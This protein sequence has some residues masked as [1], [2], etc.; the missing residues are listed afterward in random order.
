MKKIISLILA[1]VLVL[2]M[3]MIASATTYDSDPTG[4]EVQW[5]DS[6]TESQTAKIL[7]TGDRNPVYNVEVTWTSLEF[8]YSYGDDLLWNP[9]THEYDNQQVGWGTRSATVTVVNHSNAQVKCTVSA[10]DLNGRDAYSVTLNDDDV[11][12]VETLANAEDV[13]YAVPGNADSMQVTIVP[14]GTPTIEEVDQTINI[15]TITALIE[16]V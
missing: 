6:N 14:I 10:T 4:S 12:V 16:K 13:A 7:V 15:A 3:A 1:A 5:Q 11:P 2:S 8:T 9:A